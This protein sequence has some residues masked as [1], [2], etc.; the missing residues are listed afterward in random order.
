MIKHG[1]AYVREGQEAAEKK[2]Q[3]NKL[4]A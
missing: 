2:F 3:E 4:N 1:E